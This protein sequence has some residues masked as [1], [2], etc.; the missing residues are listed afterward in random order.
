M[1]SQLLQ[2]HSLNNDP[3]DRRTQVWA[4]EFQPDPLNPGKLIELKA[5]RMISSKSLQQKSVPFQ[6]QHDG[7]SNGLSFFHSSFR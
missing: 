5:S 1:L 7:R 4:C 2:T 3:T 6:I